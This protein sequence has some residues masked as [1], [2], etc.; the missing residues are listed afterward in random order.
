MQHNVVWFQS[1]VARSQISLVTMLGV[2]FSTVTLGQELVSTSV[3]KDLS[4][5]QVVE[6]ISSQNQMEAT[7]AL[8]QAFERGTRVIPLLLK[9]KDDRRFY[10]GKRLGR[11]RTGDF[12]I[13]PSNANYITVDETN[14]ETIEGAALYLISAIYFGSLEFTHSAF[15]LDTCLREEEREVGN[16]QPLLARAWASTERW[17]L[18]LE[19]KGLSTMFKEK[20]N[21]LSGSGVRFYGSQ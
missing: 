15:L 19:G 16:T 17:S 14:V 12:K 9:L 1:H 18:E 4:D 8:N 6:K 10:Y 13:D 21:P 3:M 20:R 11:T 7:Q 5:E 2:F